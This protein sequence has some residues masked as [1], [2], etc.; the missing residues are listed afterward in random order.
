MLSRRKSPV[1]PLRRPHWGRRKRALTFRG[2]RR[3]LPLLH[4]LQA[5]GNV[6]KLLI[7]ISIPHKELLVLVDL[8]AAFIKDLPLTLD[9]NQ[10][11][12]HGETRT[13]DVGHPVP[14]TS[15][16]INKVAQMTTFKDLN[17]IKQSLE[18]HIFLV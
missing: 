1:L 3:L 10:V 13:V 16:S 12:L 2:P 17:E 8:L 14:G 7:A 6:Q 11:L 4:D 15:F 5:H 18:M 9:G